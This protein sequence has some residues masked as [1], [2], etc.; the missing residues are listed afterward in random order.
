[1]SEYMAKLG[2]ASSLAAEVMTKFKDALH[3]KKEKEET[4]ND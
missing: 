1:M 2:T 3:T 4:A